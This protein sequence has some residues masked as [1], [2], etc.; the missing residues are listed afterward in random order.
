VQC[1]APVLASDPGH[2]ARATD[3]GIASRGRSR[4]TRKTGSQLRCHRRPI[5]SQHQHRQ[6]WRSRPAATRCPTTSAPP[7][8]APT[9]AA[10][11]ATAP[12]A[13]LLRP[14][15]RLRPWRTVVQPA[16]VRQPPTK[17]LRWRD[18]RCADASE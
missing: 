16:G 4:G 8:M 14:P 2:T 5:S 15:G 18:R 13:Q 12:A 1:P 9:K 17:R 3:S 10:G 7:K 6:R 11:T